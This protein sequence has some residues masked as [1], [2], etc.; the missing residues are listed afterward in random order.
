MKVENGC[1]AG[2]PARLPPLLLFVKPRRETTDD[3]LDGF[4]VS[5]MIGAEAETGLPIVATSCLFAFVDNPATKLTVCE[6]G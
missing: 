2:V 5:P 3:V 6:G 1:R 4:G